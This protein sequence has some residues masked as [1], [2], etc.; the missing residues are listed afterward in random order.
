MLKRVGDSIPV[1]TATE[2]CI[3]RRSP[4]PSDAPGM[5][6]GLSPPNAAAEGRGADCDLKK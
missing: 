6:T 2:I 5:W 3:G 1:A 4:G